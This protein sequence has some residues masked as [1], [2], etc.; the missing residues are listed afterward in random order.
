MLTNKIHILWLKL[1]REDKHFRLSFPIPLYIFKELLDCILDLLEL[2]CFLV[3]EKNQKDNSQISFYGAKIITQM[4]MNLF[5]TLAEGEPFNFFDVKTNKI[6]V[7]AKI[8]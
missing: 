6:R 8:M 1:Q 3:P 5:D 7:S 4:G 2:A